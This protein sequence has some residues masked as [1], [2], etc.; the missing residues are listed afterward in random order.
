MKRNYIQ[1]TMPA[2][3]GWSVMIMEASGAAFAR[4]YCFTDDKSSVYLDSL[5]VNN[6][7]RMKGIGTEL[8]ILREQI[9]ILSGGVKSFLWVKK[10]T[11]MLEW[12]KRRGYQYY[13]EHESEADCVWLIK[14]LI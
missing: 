5:H 1:H 9:G 6:K 3:W 14:Y 13:S 8:Q 7:A 4:V 12:Y 11:W 10:D 2:A